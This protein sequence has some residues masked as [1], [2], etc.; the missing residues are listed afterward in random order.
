MSR[1]LQEAGGAAP[2]L[3]DDQFQLSAG[4]PEADGGHGSLPGRSEP[5]R[6]DGGGGHPAQPGQLTDVKSSSSSLIHREKSGLETGYCC[7]DKHGT[8][9]DNSHKDS[10]TSNMERKY[11]TG[12]QMGTNF[13]ILYIY[14]YIDY[15][16][17][18]CFFLYRHCRTAGY[19]S[20]HY[21]LFD[22]L[23]IFFYGE[24]TK[25]SLTTF[26]FVGNHE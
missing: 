20:Q 10:K 12:N 21:F 18:S 24:I 26:F 8:Y 9:R 15:F 23:G 3:P 16:I 25:L 17:F 1:S 11:M 13:F 19:I 4:R 22:H 14:I 7:I 2:T 6:P 5:V